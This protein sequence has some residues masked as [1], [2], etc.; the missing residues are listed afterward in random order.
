[1]NFVLEICDSRDRDIVFGYNMAGLLC[2][3]LFSVF[4]VGFLLLGGSGK[5]FYFVDCRGGFWGGDGLE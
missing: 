3:V 1:M 5:C 2:F 4:L